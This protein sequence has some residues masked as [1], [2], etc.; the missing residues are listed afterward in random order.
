MGCAPS[1]AAAPTTATNVV[2]K[3]DNS[4]VAPTASAKDAS[5]PAVT[6]VASSPLPLPDPALAKQQTP[7]AQLSLAPASPIHD[8]SAC[9][10]AGVASSDDEDGEKKK[11][12]DRKGKDG[13]GGDD[14]EVAN[15]SKHRTGSTER[16]ALKGGANASFNSSPP[17]GRGGSGSNQEISTTATA[18][19]TPLNVEI[20]SKPSQVLQGDV[21][22]Q[23][24]IDVDAVSKLLPFQP[25]CLRQQAIGDIKARF[26][27]RLLC[28]CC[29]DPDLPA[30]WHFWS[31]RYA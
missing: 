10:S 28:V 16:A 24:Y 4:A 6:K 15:A 22:A 2:R 27:V 29:R 12:G 7:Q 9:Y 23:E 26:C 31:Y 13:G 30:V 19:S 3:G 8:R 11:D 14:D 17:H 5:P 21:E 1:V 20:A 18:L 25:N